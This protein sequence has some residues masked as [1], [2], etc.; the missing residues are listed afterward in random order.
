MCIDL[1]NCDAYDEPARSGCQ[2]LFFAD[3][4]IPLALVFPNG[5]RRCQNQSL[6]SEDARRREAEVQAAQRDARA[7]SWRIVGREA[8][9]G[10]F[11]RGL[12]GLG[13]AALGVGHERQG[14]QRGALGVENQPRRTG[15]AA[16]GVGHKKRGLENGRLGVENQP[17]EL[18]HGPREAENQRLEV[19]NQRLEVGRKKMSFRESARKAP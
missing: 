2:A 1:T 11:P 8:A 4:K 15:N 6:P 7:C 12:H 5:E 10:G 3:L 16:P 13:S 9:A 14:V 17:P 19:E 18:G